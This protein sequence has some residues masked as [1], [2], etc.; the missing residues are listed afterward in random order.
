MSSVLKA[1]SSADRGAWP[2]GRRRVRSLQ[3]ALQAALAS[4][5]RGHLLVDAGGVELFRNAEAARLLG[6]AADPCATLA[7]RG[8]SDERAQADIGR[9]RLAA[10]LGNFQQVELSLPLPP[11]GREWLAV[12]VKGL[13]DGVVHW[14]VEDISARRAIDETW[15]REREMLADFIDFMPVGFYSA[16]T[17]GRFRF[18]N[19]RL[20]EWIG[21]SAEQLVGVP[22]VDVLGVEPDPEEDR[23][24]M[25]LRGRNGDVFQAFV[26]H[27]VF[28][29]GGETLTRSV[30]VRDL[31]PERH[32]ERALKVAERRFRWLFEDSPVAIALV[33]PDGTISLANAALQA[34]VGTDPAALG[35]RAVTDFINSDDCAAV[36][37]Q[38]SRVLLGTAAGVHLPVRLKADMSLGGRDLAATL[39]IGQTDE[40]G[41]LSGLILHFIDTTERKNLEIQIVQNQKMQAM[42]QLAGGIAHDFNNLLTAMIGFC[43]LLL[44]RHAPGDISFADIMQIKQNANRAASLVRQLLAFS[45]R[46]ALQPKLFDVTDALADLSNLLR[47]LLGETI[48][49]SITHGRGLGLVRVDPGQFDQVII[50][51]AVNARDAMPGGGELSVCTRAMV[52]E[53]PYQ[54]GDEIMPP[55]SYVVIEVADTGSG[56]AAEH[57]ARIFEPFFST[58]EVGAGTGLGLSTVYGIVRQTDG[59]IFVDSAPNRGTVFSIY[60]PRF[61]PAETLTQL[62][63]PASD[64][65]RQSGDLTGAGVVLIVEDEDAVRLFGAR[66]LRNQGYQ[67]IEASSAEIALD[68]LATH[69]LVDVLVTDMVMPGMD[70]AS[71][72]RQVRVERPQ[73]QV[74]LMS[75]YSEDLA[76]AE[77]TGE[78]GMYFLPKPFSLKQLASMVK[79]AMQN[80]HAKDKI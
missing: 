72:A 31:I 12:S 17:E 19:Q 11:D 34:M 75:G 67:V 16:D 26:T 25:R 22:L 73:I 61:E 60:L 21:R 46:Q 3:R 41:A 56:I 38:M 47:R 64:A 69:P 44:Q 57:L 51:L 15:R 30:V 45:R 35:G 10:E 7:A 37:E 78:D 53:R 80:R 58:K 4:D 29:E 8:D 27:T 68:A 42:G 79:D 71:L 65:P 48:Q 18:V 70:G 1:N 52:M 54:R 6:P 36:A 33:D 2:F 43:D 14:I 66:A 39:Y 50:N 62:P 55:G 40:D 9:L 74:I 5:P 13:P 28:D 20:A 59:F 32:R 77:L 63:P 23:A 49:L 76:P 24:E